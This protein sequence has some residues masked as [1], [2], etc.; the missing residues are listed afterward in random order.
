MKLL[1]RYANGLTIKGL[2]G[3]GLL[4][5]ATSLL[6][7]LP[8]GTFLGT[9]KDA[10]GAVVAGANITVT[11]TETGFTRN[12]TSEADGSYRLS[13]LPVGNYQLRVTHEGFQTEE[14]S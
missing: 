14:R 2:A 11:N 7:Q 10:S 1:R 13:A 5:L 6:A 8:T 9:V 12:T 3:L 4:F